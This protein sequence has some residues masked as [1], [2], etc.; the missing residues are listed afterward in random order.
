[1]PSDQIGEAEPSTP[2][3]ECAGK[4]VGCCFS[5]RYR[6]ELVLLAAVVVVLLSPSCK[7]ISLP[8]RVIVPT[9]PD[10]QLRLWSDRCQ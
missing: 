2:D 9:L 4:C 3:V 5:R 10:L 6:D 8:G 1:M 7:E